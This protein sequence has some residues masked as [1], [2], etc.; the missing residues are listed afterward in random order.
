MLPLKNRKHNSHKFLLIDRLV[1]SMLPQSY[2]NKQLNGDLAL[3]QPLTHIE[4]HRSQA[5]TFSK[6]WPWL[7]PALES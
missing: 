4:K 1:A 3:G 7:K 5:R 6:N 2:Y